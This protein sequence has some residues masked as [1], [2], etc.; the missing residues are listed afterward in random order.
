MVPNRSEM[1]FNAAPRPMRAFC[2]G[3]SA[4]P[5]LHFNYKLQEKTKQLD[6]ITDGHQQCFIKLIKYRLPSLSLASPKK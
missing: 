1:D 6:D 5:E 3:V 4:D 2:S